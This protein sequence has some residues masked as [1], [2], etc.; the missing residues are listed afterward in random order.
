[1]LEGDF[2]VENEELDKEIKKLLKGV[3]SW[4]TK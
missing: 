2:K 3:K 1:L 4:A